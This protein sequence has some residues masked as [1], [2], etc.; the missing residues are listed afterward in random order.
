[1]PM[2]QDVVFALGGFVL[3]GGLFP[4][5][6]Q[7]EKPP[8]RSSLTVAG[9]LTAYVAAM[10]TLGLWLAATSTGVQVA[11]WLVLALQRFRQ[12][13]RFPDAEIATRPG[14]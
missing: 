3:S 2:W 12:R 4:M 7:R 13:H 9:V 14:D 8:L 10:V 6:R 5:V 11:V 1:M